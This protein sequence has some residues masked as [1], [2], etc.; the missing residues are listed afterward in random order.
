MIHAHEVKALATQT[1]T[2]A[3]GIAEDIVRVRGAIGDVRAAQAGLSE[4]VDT[5]DGL[6]HA[7]AGAIVEQTRAGREISGHVAEASVA[8]DHIRANIAEILHGARTAGEDAG[9]MTQLAGSLA[10]RADELERHVVTFLDAM[11]A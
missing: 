1:R 5:V 8:T 9:A 6:S 4:A 10:V 11:V 3:A 7:V 2:A